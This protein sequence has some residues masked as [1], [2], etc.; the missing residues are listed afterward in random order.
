MPRSCPPVLPSGCG[1]RPGGGQPP[2]GLISVGVQQPHPR[3]GLLGRAQG[4][5]QPQAAKRALNPVETPA[6]PSFPAVCRCICGQRWKSGLSSF[7]LRVQIRRATSTR[8]V[9]GNRHLSGHRINN[10]PRSWQPGIHPCLPAEENPRP[11]P[12]LRCLGPGSLAKKRREE[13]SAPRGLPASGR[14]R[15]KCWQGR[16]GKL[17]GGVVPGG[18]GMP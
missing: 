9:G 1:G 5:C 15:A 14:Q 3:R 2:L 13:S 10:L 8:P 7:P 18:A 11:E 12:R 16:G 4:V 6:S 17:S